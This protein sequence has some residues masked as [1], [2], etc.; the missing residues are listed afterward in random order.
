MNIV[1]CQRCGYKTILAT[2]FV[3]G[4]VPDQ[5]PYESGKVETCGLDEI[6]TV[7]NVDIHIYW[8]ERCEKIDTVWIDNPR[9][10]HVDCCE[11]YH[12]MNMA[13]GS[14]CFN[15]TRRNGYPAL[16]Q[17]NKNCKNFKLKE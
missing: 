17:P 1:E 14:H 6:V 3:E 10:N 9:L 13:R 5:E 15:C 7:E 2:G 8:C 11:N 16:A 12:R 4:F